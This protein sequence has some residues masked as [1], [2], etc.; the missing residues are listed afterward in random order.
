MFERTQEL[1]LALTRER[2]ELQRE[3]EA[4]EELAERVHQLQRILDAERLVTD[5]QGKEIARL[6]ELLKARTSENDDLG[7]KLVATT[8]AI[9]TLK[10]ERDND[11]SVFEQNVAIMQ[12]KHR[13]LVEEDLVL[14][15]RL[16]HHTFLAIK[17]SMNLNFDLPE[18]IQQAMEESVKFEDIYDWLN[19]K[20]CLNSSSPSRRKSRII[21]QEKQHDLPA[22]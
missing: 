5:R 14:K 2:Q 17:L 6:A 11:K 3:R 7:K 15:K 13:M 1:E 12:E 20:L 9:E 4:R 19:E 18:M 22:I 8:K 10:A 21:K 16:Y